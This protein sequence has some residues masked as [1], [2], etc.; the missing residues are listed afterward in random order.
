MENL[1]AFS[2]REVKRAAAKKQVFLC[3]RTVSVKEKY[4]VILT[5]FL[6]IEEGCLLERKTGEKGTDRKIDK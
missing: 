2:V 1:A 3:T 4:K 5:S 6:E